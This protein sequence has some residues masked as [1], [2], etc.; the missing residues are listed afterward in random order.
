LTAQNKESTFINIPLPYDPNA[1]ADPEIWGSNF[2]PISLHGSIEH[3]GSDVKNIKDFLR[4]MTKYIT[5]KQIESSK[6]NNLDN[7][8]GI[9]EAVWNFISS[10]YK[11]NWDTLYTDNN[12]ISL[13]R[14]IA[15]KFTPKI[16]PT[17]Q[18]TSKKKNSPSL[19]NIKRLPPPIPTK[20]PKEVNEISKFFKS[21]KLV[22]LAANKSK[23]YAQAS[24][25]NVS[26]ANVIK[27]KETFPSVG[28]KEINQINN[29][30]KGPSK[31][32]PYIQLTTKGP[33]RKQIIIPMVKDNINRFMK[34]S[35]IH[36]ANLNR[37]LRNAKSKVLVD[38]I[39]SDP[40]GITVITNKVPLNS[41][42]LTIEKYVKNL[43]N[44][45]STQVE[46]PWLPQSKSYLK[47]IGILYY[48]HGSYNSQECFSSKDVKDIIKQNQ[49]FD[50]ITLASKPRVIKVSPKSDMVIVWI[51]I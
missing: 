3:L 41:N 5:N 48:S 12:S 26:M 18:K 43:E 7:F 36:V 24:K 31:L 44:I 35:S 32:K 29:I 23:S 46:T 1:P 17:S 49:I 20:T 19:A 21:S 39:H 51:D 4:F 13:R 33:S 22:N 2:H 25:Q 30:I 8:K 47:I 34:N 16:Q 37:N 45:N 10:V 9:G 38:F 40:L 28:T 6:T 27:I 14:K 50:N 11:A 42:L 15:S